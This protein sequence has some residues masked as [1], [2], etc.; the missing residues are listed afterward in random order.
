MSST[1]PETEMNAIAQGPTP[2]SAITGG[3][4]EPVLELDTGEALQVAV[5]LHR[6]GELGNAELL[7]R[8]ILAQVPGHPDALHFIGILH[9]QRG[10]NAESID[11]LAHSIALD[12]T[13]PDRHSNLGN[14]LLELDR[15]DEAEQAY[16]QAIALDP[17]HANAHN[18]L[19]ALLRARGRSEEARDA[20]EQAIASNPSQADAY[21]N[22]G[23]LYSGLG[24]PAQALACYCKAITLV[25]GHPNARKLLGI[26]YY[27]LGETE[28]AAEVFTQW[29]A[30]EPD[31]PV[32]RHM[33]AAS[34]GSDVPARASDAF[35]E[36]TFDS[37][38]ASFDVKLGKLDYRAPAL[39]AATLERTC[40]AG[41]H[42]LNVL[43]AGCG[44]GLCGPLLASHARHLVGVDLS[45][46][47]LQRARARGVYD[48]LEKAELAAYLAAH[49]GEFDVVVSADT[50]VYFGALEAVFDAAWQALRPGGILIFTV[51][52]AG[53][54]P[55]AY[56]LNPHGRYSHGRHYIAGRMARAGLSVEALDAAVLRK[57]GGKPV[58]GLVVA[59]RKA[60][61][62]TSS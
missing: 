19:G 55:D 50:L 48:A 15:Y 23:N 59:G 51:E 41:A 3:P 9:H 29:L 57:E 24:Q 40:G 22:L 33:L 53:D 17:G 52:E 47:M 11:C 49:P 18:N 20:F 39:V 8:R 58:A 43:D 6:M 10:R 44:T 54:A 56:R 32:A 2:D 5:E 25:P 60:V 26:A 30:D 13:L 42:G 16:R 31:N 27:T 37:F 14:V 12:P 7:Y 61:L 28:K 34:S 46:G 45:S 4:E 36:S 1:D 21:S 62:G 38:A 35:I